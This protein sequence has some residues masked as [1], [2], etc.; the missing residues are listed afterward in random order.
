MWNCLGA[1]A[2]FVW[3]KP[4]KSVAVFLWDLFTF[5]QDQTMDEY[6]FKISL[7]KGG[8]DS[9]IAAFPEWFTL[10]SFVVT[11]QYL[12]CVTFCFAGA[13]VSVFKLWGIWFGEFWKT[14]F[15]RHL[16]LSFPS[17]VRCLC[18]CPAPLLGGECILMML[19]QFS[20]LIIT[21]I[22]VLFL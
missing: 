13:N 12:L 7:L 21:L 17:R 22:L 3:K 1:G 16:S 10:N 14:G 20:F 6:I 4:L 18:A 8:G 19:Y 5:W 15:L 9:S 2:D 11:T